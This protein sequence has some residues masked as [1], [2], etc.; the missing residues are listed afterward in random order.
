M[1]N[2]QYKVI[3]SN[4]CPSAVTSSAVTLTVT[5]PSVITL[6]PA[7]T[8]IC[9][10]N[11]ASF[12]VTATGT[13]L[14]YQW[15]VST[16]NGGTWNNVPGATSATLTLN[17]VTVGMNNNR[18]RVVISSCAPGG[19]ISN[20]ATLTV[21]AGVAISTQPVN[22]SACS[23]TNTSFSVTA[24]GSCPG[25]SMA[26]KHKWRRHIYG[27]TRSNKR[28]PEFKFSDCCNEQ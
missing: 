21:N 18:Y 14:T 2:N 8:T 13:S 25:L 27:Y 22:V 4:A 19:L 9:S 10:G 23:G 5:S 11:N 6:Q 24:N 28:H 15:Q 3:V 1:N 26:N 20:A 7:N 12:V 17:A 16:D